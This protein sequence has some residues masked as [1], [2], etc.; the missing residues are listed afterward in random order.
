MASS[1]IEFKSF[2]SELIF[3][4]TVNKNRSSSRANITLAGF[5]YALTSVVSIIETIAASTFALLSLPFS[6]SGIDN[7]IF[8]ASLERFNSSSFCLLWSVVDFILNPS[9]AVLVADETSAR[10]IANSGNILYLPEGAII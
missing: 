7:K 5:G 9:I 10:K 4:N 6:L 2:S 3:E 8:D 1:N